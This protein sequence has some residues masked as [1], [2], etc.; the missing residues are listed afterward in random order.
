MRIVSVPLTVVLFL[1]TGC[2]QPDVPPPVAPDSN[3]WLPP[4]AAAQAT[5]LIGRD[6]CA[7][8][9]PLR[10][11]FFGDLHTHTAISLD[12]M[13]RGG[14]QTPDD[15]YRF[16]KGETLSLSAVDGVQRVAQIERPLD[17]AAVTDH[18][19]WMGETLACSDPTSTTF[20]SEI[21]THARAGNFQPLAT[22]P[23]SRGRLTELCG[24]D[25]S[26]CRAGI[27][28]AWEDTQAAA[29]RHYDRSSTCT[30]TTLL[31]WEY[32]R[33]P[34]RSMTHRNIILRNEVTP[35][36]PIASI[37]APTPEEM[38]TKLKERCND[39]ATGCEAIS[40]PHNPN[41]SNGQ[42][43][44][45]NFGNEDPESQRDYLM[46]R[47]EMEPLVEMMQAKGASECRRGMWQV[48]GDDDP[49]CDFEQGRFIDNAPPEDCETGTGTGATAGEGCQSRL[50]F[51]RYAL[52]EGLAQ[53]ERIGINP[54][55]FGFIAS[56]DGHNGAPG[57][58]DENQY[59]GH[60]SN[61]DSD[62]AQRLDNPAYVPHRLRNPGG[63]VGVWAEQNA[64]DS[65]FDALRRREVF[66][67][68]GTRIR[69]RFFGG[70]DLPELCASNEMIADAYASGVP[71]GETL[72]TGA[73]DQSP[74]FFVSA[75]A[76]AGAPERAATPLQR[77][78]I[79]KGWHPGD[80]VFEQRVFDVAG[81]PD[82]GADVSRETCARSGSGAASLCTVWR[83]PDFDPT[84]SAVY[85]ARVVENPSCR[86]NAFQCA[87]SAAPD[88]PAACRDPHTPWK[89]QERAWT[90]PIW[91]SARS[92]AS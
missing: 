48:E 1:L 89:I 30:F 43:F 69:V 71:M 47:R 73:Y 31:G 15:A 14:F 46:L 10:Q 72:P 67:T 20:A 57:D 11:A 25:A 77:I 3:E 54:Y 6:P 12:A 35:E 24:A 26:Q 4:S 70:W 86:W 23:R 7:N 53:E 39:N 83:D 75:L 44:T 63:L 32:T 55:Q 68:S 18:A 5:P 78:Q 16:A 80:G 21:C 81:D 22:A 66:G 64:R 37:D 59:Q 74:M 29:E 41:I 38:W 9:E 82:N 56:T 34:E 19:E 61:D 65:I 51:A 88:R 42:M 45:L 79:I 33:A 17:F 84:Q 8:H 58:T 90:S 40:I 2:G 13:G 36:L 91:Y 85:Y 49:L 87:E 27:A 50:D 76:D 92:D 62:L 28:S 60:N 52:I